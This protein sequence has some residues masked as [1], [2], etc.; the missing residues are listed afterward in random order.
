MTDQEAFRIRQDAATRYL[1]L[2]HY[3]RARFTQRVQGALAW[4]AGAVLFISV[5]GGLV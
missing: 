5:I 3:Q 2:K 1:A 4:V